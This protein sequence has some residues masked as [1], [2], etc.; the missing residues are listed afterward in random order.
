MC[1]WLIVGWGVVADET[2]SRRGGRTFDR[3]IDGGM[4]YGWNAP[5]ERMST[6]LPRDDAGHVSRSA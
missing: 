3:L 4:P 5:I 2:E 6:C 1:G